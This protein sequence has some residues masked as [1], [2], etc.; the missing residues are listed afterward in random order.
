MPLS[1]ETVL[2]KLACPVRAV[3]IEGEADSVE[4]RSPTF[5]EWHDL[6]RRHRELNG[7]EPPAELVAETVAVC[8]ANPDGSRMFPAEEAESVRGLPPEFVMRVYVAAWQTVL[9]GL[10]ADDAEKKS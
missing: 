1:R 9:R 4:M 6:V 8:L 7:S 10:Y 5:L 2:S 3:A